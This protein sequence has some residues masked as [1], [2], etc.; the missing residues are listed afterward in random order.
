MEKH[1]FEVETVR[2]VVDNT[3]KDDIEIRPHANERGLV[4]IF[5]TETGTTYTMYPKQA[6]LVAQALM[7]CSY[8][9]ENA[10]AQ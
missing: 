10:N 4:E 7:L 2:R 1:N 3:G 9:V 8:E 6:Q 5:C